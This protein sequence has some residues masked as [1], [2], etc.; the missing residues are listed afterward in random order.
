LVA[1]MNDAMGVEQVT[2]NNPV[3]VPSWL[4]S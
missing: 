3:E 4:A 2:Y 1:H